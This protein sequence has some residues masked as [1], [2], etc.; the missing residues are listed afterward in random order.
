M[1]SM[2]ANLG[3]LAI[4]LHLRNLYYLRIDI[5]I[6]CYASKIPKNFSL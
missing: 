3:I 5:V 6:Q 1:R 4:C 2:C